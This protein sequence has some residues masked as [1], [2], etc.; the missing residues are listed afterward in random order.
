MPNNPPRPRSAE[1]PRTAR[2]EVR[3]TPGELDRL[4]RRAEASNRTVSD[5]L[6]E[7][8]AEARP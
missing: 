1:G 5:V 4:R 6:R 2:L 7:P 3:L 8:V